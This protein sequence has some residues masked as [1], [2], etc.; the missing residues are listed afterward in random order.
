MKR[1]SVSAE[2]HQRLVLRRRREGEETEVRLLPAFRHASEQLLHVLDP[3]FLG[4]LARFGVQFLTTEH[5]FQIRRRLAGLRAVRLVNDYS[6]ASGGKVPVSRL[7]S[8]FR[9]LQKLPRDE[10]ELLQGGD[11][12]RHGILQR[13]RK[14]LGV[15][16]DLLHYALPVFELV[17]SVLQ[18]L[19]QHQSVSN[20][21]HAVE[22]ALVP[23]V[24]QR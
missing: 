7:P 15:V 2:Y 8:F 9:E 16:F 24:V 23:D 21:D 19:V 14:L 4:A 1:F 13:L 3:F 22:Y 10:G 6:V 17:D 12:D 20:H 11:D 18:L 5:F